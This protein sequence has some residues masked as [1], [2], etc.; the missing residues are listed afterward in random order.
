MPEPLSAATL[1]VGSII[2]FENAKSQRRDANKRLKDAETTAPERLDENLGTLKN[3]V[4]GDQVPGST[5]LIRQGS[6]GSPVRV[7]VPTI[8]LG[9]SK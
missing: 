3:L 5:R 6:S 2:A 7:G 1:I 8:L 9:P 4:G